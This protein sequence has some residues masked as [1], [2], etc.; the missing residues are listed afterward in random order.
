M[1]KSHRCNVDHSLQ[2][3][4]FS[5]HLFLSSLRCCFFSSLLLCLSSLFCSLLDRT[6]AVVESVTPLPEPLVPY[7]SLTKLKKV[8][9]AIKSTLAYSDWHTPI[10]LAVQQTC[11][12]FAELVVA[13]CL[14]H[15]TQTMIF[16]SLLSMAP[17]S[18]HM[19]GLLYEIQASWRFSTRFVIRIIMLKTHASTIT[20]VDSNKIS[21][22]SVVTQISYEPIQ[23]QLAQCALNIGRQTKLIIFRN[24]C[25]RNLAI[26]PV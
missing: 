1:I 26:L 18:R 22:S 21:I 13:K 16:S 7:R 19:L 10:S 14:F 20:I 3:L 2:A 23:K 6:L 15:L 4:S 25:E 24:F 9:N 12:R 8:T 17:V 5:S 11:F